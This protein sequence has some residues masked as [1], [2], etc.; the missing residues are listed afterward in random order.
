MRLTPEQIER[1][2]GYLL[3]KARRDSR[4]EDVV[5]LLDTI[6]ALTVVPNEKREAAVR[7]RESEVCLAITNDAVGQGNNMIERLQSRVE[8]NRLAVAPPEARSER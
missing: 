8:A 6:D 3:D 1:R 5:D 4:F 7:L 2:R